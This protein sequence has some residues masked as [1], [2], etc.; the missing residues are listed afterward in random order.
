M[1]MQLRL[2]VAC[3]SSPEIAANLLDIYQLQTCQL[4]YTSVNIPGYIICENMKE[5]SHQQSVFWTLFTIN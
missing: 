3:S 4:F 2:L 1:C 5:M